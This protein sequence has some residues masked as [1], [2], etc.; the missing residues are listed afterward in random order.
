LYD[1]QIVKV[2][3]IANILKERNTVVRC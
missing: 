1:S 2:K 3:M